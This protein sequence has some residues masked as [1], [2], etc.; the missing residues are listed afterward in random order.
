MKHRKAVSILASLL[1]VH[2]A[3]YVCS[4]EPDLAQRGAP[5]TSAEISTQVEGSQNPVDS[6]VPVKPV[7]ISETVLDACTVRIEQRRGAEDCDALNSY[8]SRMGRQPRN[9]SWAEGTEK[10]LRDYI[11]STEGDFSIRLLECRESLCISEVSSIH[12]QLPL[13]ER[14]QSQGIL[15]EK[16]WP[17]TALVVHEKDPSGNGDVYGTKLTTTVTTFVR[18]VG[19]PNAEAFYWKQFYQ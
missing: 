1:S 4:S 8:I 16:L 12:G 3:S 15:I 11:E 19:P 18:R 6:D 13:D 14:W 10:L 2:C 7:A 9:V 17:R 5:T